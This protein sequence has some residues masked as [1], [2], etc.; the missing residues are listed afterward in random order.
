MDIFASVENLNK[1]WFNSRN[2]RSFTNK[3]FEDIFFDIDRLDNGF[4]VYIGYRANMYSEAPAFG[5]FYYNTPEAISFSSDT[6]LSFIAHSPDNSIRKLCV[7]IKPKGRNWMHESFDFKITDKQTAYTI[8]FSEF[9]K[10]ETLDCVDEITF[11]IKPGFFTDKNTS[12]GNIT[13]TDINIICRI[14]LT[15]AGDICS[16]TTPIS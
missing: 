12:E 4:D 10:K 6:V 8:N 3:G 2:K 9:L 11:V 14:S 13:I 15:V 7:E 16:G 1:I 5:G